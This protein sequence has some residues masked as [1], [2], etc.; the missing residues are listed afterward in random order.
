MVYVL[1]SGS[2][3]VLNIFFYQDGYNVENLNLFE[4]F[5]SQNENYLKLE[6][7]IQSIVGDFIEKNIS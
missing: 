2:I 7:S 4:S 3:I 5:I 1:K 6:I